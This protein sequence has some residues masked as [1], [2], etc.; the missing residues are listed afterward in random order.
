M[1]WLGKLGR[2]RPLPSAIV[3]SYEDAAAS[4]TK[5][6]GFLYRYHPQA[7]LADKLHHGQAEGLGVRMIGTIQ[8]DVG[9]GS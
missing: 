2:N 4:C 5:K 8:Q 3:A 6:A 7:P 9:V 1:I